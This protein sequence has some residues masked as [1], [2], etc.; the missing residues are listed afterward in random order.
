LGWVAEEDRDEERLVKREWILSM[1]CEI[2]STVA[3][4][5]SAIIGLAE[6]KQKSASMEAGYISAVVCII[7]IPSLPNT[8]RA[9]LLGSYTRLQTPT[10]SD[11][12]H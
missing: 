12:G 4:H 7:L 9:Y 1:K 2:C 11:V 8:S 3:R 5:A 10:R 6:R